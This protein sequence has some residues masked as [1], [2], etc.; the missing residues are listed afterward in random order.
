M[1]KFETII[2]ILTSIIGV[3]C[4]VGNFSFNFGRWFLIKRINF[5]IENMIKRGQLL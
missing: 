2:V 1:N 4:T 3:I 5:T